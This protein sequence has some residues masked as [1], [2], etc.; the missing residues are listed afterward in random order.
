M[1]VV[2]L[3]DSLARMKA[4]RKYAPGC[5]HVETVEA[6]II[7]IRNIEKIDELWLDHDLGGQH[8]VP[9]NSKDCGYEVVRFLQENNYTDKI[10]KITVHSMNG[11]AAPFMHDDLVKAGYNAYYLPFIDFKEK[12]Q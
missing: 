2:V 8:Y 9:S 6:C 3:E 12:I 1:T 11:Y 10:A 4:F 5:I 7:A